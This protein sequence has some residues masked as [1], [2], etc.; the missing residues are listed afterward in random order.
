EHR[1]RGDGGHAAVH[2]VESVRAAEEVGGRFRRTADAGELGHLLRLH[3]HFV[4]GADDLIADGV[5]AAAGAERRLAAL[6]VERFEAE[7]VFLRRGRFVGK[8]ENAFSHGLILRDRLRYRFG[9][10]ADFH[11]ARAVVFH[12]QQRVRDRARVARQT[13]V[14]Q[15]FA[16]LVLD[17]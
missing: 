1:A 11:D 2:A 16:Q 13:G 5:V 15:Y 10:E 9:A 6:V 17:I 14:V 3:V 7:A 4:K 8:F 12:L